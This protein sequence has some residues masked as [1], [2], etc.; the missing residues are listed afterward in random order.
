M[1]DL[2]ILA[3]VCLL[4]CSACQPKLLYTLNPAAEGHF[5][6]NDIRYDSLEDYNALNYYQ[7][8]EV[9]S[10]RFNNFPLEPFPAEFKGFTNVQYVAFE[11]YQAW[12]DLPETIYTWTKIEAL[13]A[14]NLN[15][16]KLPKEFIRLQNLKE[17]HLAGNGFTSFPEEIC[18]SKLEYLW[19]NNNAI[20]NLPDLPTCLPSIQL[21]DIS[22]N[23]ASAL[24]EAEKLKM[25]EKLPQT[26][27]IW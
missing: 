19:I 4:F 12:Y 10:V 11:G 2:R 1:N 7:P 6:V 21:I 26:T 13:E 15:L 24:G 27:F 16:S 22:G 17:L 8:K 25:Q 5:W 18:S 9:W 20:Q 14:E 3:I 23:S